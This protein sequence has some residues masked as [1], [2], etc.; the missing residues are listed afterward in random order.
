VPLIALEEIGCNYAL[1]LVAFAAGEHKQDDFLSVNP[2]GKVPALATDGVVVTENIA[3]QSYLAERF[4]DARLLP[5][6]ANLLA[7]ARVLSDLS[8]VASTLHP[9]VTRIRM[10]PFFA[11][12]EA[13]QAVWNGGVK[14]MDEYF[15]LVDER[16]ARK[17]WWYGAQWSMLDAYLNWVF[18]RVFGA[19]YD[20]AR[21][22]HFERHD[23]ACQAR[24]SVVRALQIERE[25]EAELDRR[26]LLFRPPAPPFDQS[27]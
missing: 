15:A 19:G 20:T 24:P 23:R 18:F 2:K 4:P 3:I 10:A 22:P 8:F 17:E 16:L 6:Q 1:R 27:R 11:G 12:P 9:I 26:G 21:F 7:R 13:A 14:A 25:Q 5:A